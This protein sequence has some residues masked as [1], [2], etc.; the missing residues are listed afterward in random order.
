MIPGEERI[1]HRCAAMRAPGMV[2]SQCRQPATIHIVWNLTGE[3]GLSCQEHA[4][5]LEN[6]DYLAMHPMGVEC[7]F[8]GAAFVVA[9]N[10]CIAPN[11]LGPPR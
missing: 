10:R 8:A 11:P 9:D 5:A 2:N 1:V 6:G 7:P 4:D 3:S